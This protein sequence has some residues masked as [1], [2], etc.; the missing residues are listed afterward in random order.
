MNCKTFLQQNS[1]LISKSF[2][3]FFDLTTVCAL[4]VHLSNEIHAKFT[5]SSREKQLLYFKGKI[6]Q[7]STIQNLFK[8]MCKDI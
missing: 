2:S 5:N 3:L 4:I 8:R 1:F 7:H 6:M